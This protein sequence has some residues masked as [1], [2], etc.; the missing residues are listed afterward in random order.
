M[1]L[2]KFLR[3]KPTT[4]LMIAMEFSNILYSTPEINAV[5][6]VGIGGFAAADGL[7]AELFEVQAG[8]AQN[9]SNTLEGLLEIMEMNPTLWNLCDIGP[10]EGAPV[11]SLVYPALP[12][13]ATGP[14]AEYY[15][16]IYL[17]DAYRGKV[18]L[19][20]KST[21][22]RRAYRVTYEVAG[23]LKKGSQWVNPRIAGSFYMLESY[24]FDLD[25][26]VVQIQPYALVGLALFSASDSVGVA[27][28]RINELS[29][30][31]GID[32][33]VATLDEVYRESVKDDEWFMGLLSRLMGVVLF[34]AFAIMICMQTVAI[35][36]SQKEY[37]IL[38]SSGFLRSDMVK[39]ITF[40][41]VMTSIFSVAL[42]HTAITLLVHGRFSG[43]PDSYIRYILWERLFPSAV[44]LAA[45]VTAITLAVA[46]AVID[47]FPVVKLIKEG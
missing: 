23:F 42:S 38:L 46:V 20:R 5:G 28:R 21:I 25:Y 32:V 4:L 17:G 19:G 43:S 33:S 30:E 22:D 3:D 34:S 12:E 9:D 27:Q 8:H 13:P 47:K 40:K 41:T 26:A 29:N 6:S 45:T 16:Y 11:E 24:S 10:A 37:G 18:E 14:E 39:I 44:L 31:Y 2:K 7:L 1:R 36:N 15:N 35:Y